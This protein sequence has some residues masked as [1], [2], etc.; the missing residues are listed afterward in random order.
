MNTLRESRTLSELLHR[1]GRRQP[2]ATAM[3]Y[4]GRATR[5][6]ALD[7][8]VTQI[9]NG[10]A[11]F[12]IR[13][14]DRIG[15]L[16]K[17]S[18]LYLELLLG[19][20]RAGAVLVPLNWRFAAPEIDT[21]LA[22]AG[23]SI[24]FV[25]PGF[26]A[27]PEELDQRNT[28]RCISVDGASGLWPEFL[29][30]RDA[31]SLD[32]QMPGEP[33]DTVIQMYTSGT[34]GRP[35]GVE[36]SNR[37]I[38]AIMTAAEDG[39]WGAI[40]RNDV[41]LM[42]MPA[43]HVAGT[44]VGLIGLAHGSTVIVMAEFDPAALIEAIPRYHVT[45]LLLVPA[46]ILIL[47][48][49]PSSASADFSSVRSLIYGASPIAEALLERARTAF[50]KAGLWH[51]YGLTEASGG[52]TIL[53]PDAHDPTLGKLRSCGKP[54]LRIVDPAG[55]PVPSGEVGEIVLRS[56][57]VMKGYWNNPEATRAAFFPDGWLR[58]G[59]AAY[60]DDDGYVYVHD[61]VKDMIISGAENVYP[62]E[63]ENALFGHPAIAD[64]AVIGVPDPHWGE[65]VKAMVVLRPGHSATADEIIAHARLRIA[66]FKVPK[67]IDFLE[68]LPRNAA[69]KLLRRVLREPYWKD[70]DHQ[71]A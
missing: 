37:N 1:V 62:A 40:L 13:H 51:L 35:K 36:L 14:Q 64:V 11:G 61:R 5:Y 68:A 66:G 41:G 15:Y 32:D 34:T 67:S 16:G 65:A 25:G 27:V 50:G 43:S 8:H 71:V 26:E 19:A 24:L 45:S 55:Q 3:I 22:D 42:C 20:A 48:Q 2:D 4:S 69:G 53:P 63:V 44:A 59:D 6:A 21:I 46:A 52:G 30:W 9:A 29:D 49:H 54:D 23:I 7:R 28:L 18:D 58:T 12:G 57:T 17:S 33:E 56:A 31:Q 60:L 70:R 38:L 39:G 10:L 47:V